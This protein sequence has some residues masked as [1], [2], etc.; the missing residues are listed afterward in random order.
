M[1]RIER[2]YEK[3]STSHRTG[4]APDDL[5]FFLAH[6]TVRTGEVG[7]NMII[8]AVVANSCQ[9]TVFLK[10]KMDGE[11]ILSCNY[12]RH[13]SGP[14]PYIVVYKDVEFLEPPPPSSTA[15]LAQSNNLVLRVN[16]FVTY[17]THT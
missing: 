17:R 4:Y 13:I 12:F 10:D 11:F 3:R 9:R 8:Q 1:G 7:S 6:S 15:N 14:G 16:V 2:T 5:H